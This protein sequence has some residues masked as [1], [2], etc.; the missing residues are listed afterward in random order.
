MTRKQVRLLLISAGDHER[1]PDDD[2]D[3]ES[4]DLTKDGKPP[5][6][7]QDMID[8]LRK[9]V[10]GKTSKVVDKLVGK[11]LVEEM[12]RKKDEHKNDKKNKP[13]SPVKSRSNIQRP[14]RPGLTV[15]PIPVS[16]GNDDLIKLAMQSGSGLKISNKL[17]NKL[18][19]RK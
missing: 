4:I 13:I 10:K 16:K 9:G 3:D 12:D 5:I 19:G 14:P 15:K 2:K 18:S 6:I 1:L 11:N 8:R 7:T 17:R